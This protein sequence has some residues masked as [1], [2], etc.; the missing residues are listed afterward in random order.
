MNAERRSTYLERTVGELV[1]EDY[2]RA[3]VFTG[4]GI[5]FCCG[6]RR[7]AGDACAAAGVDPER[8][9]AALESLDARE[10]PARGPE[11]RTWPLR[12]LVGHIQD[13]HHAYV[14]RT[15]PVLDAWTE[16]LAG[17]HGA[18]HPELLEVRSLFEELADE[19]PR[20]LDAEESALFP[21]L[22][23]LETAG[24]DDDTVGAIP[25]SILEVLEDDHDHAGAIVRR[26]REITDGFSPPHGA[27]ATY[28]ATFHLLNEFEEDLHRH[29]HLENN[30][31]FPRA[32]AALAEP[33]TKQ[34]E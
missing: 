5:D 2:G 6:G 31:L 34:A 3:A 22:A 27:C 33:E 20:H 11:P 7:S 30:V 18:R 28:R 21:R 10:G 13:E 32:R 12:R 16:K 25:E 9:T 17:V 4:L 24:G 23:S 1:A 15:L 29:V 8:L 19:L 26:M 14:R